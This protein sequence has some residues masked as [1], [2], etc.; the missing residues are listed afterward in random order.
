MLALALALVL[1][2]VWEWWCAWT[3]VPHRVGC[4]R[5]SAVCMY[6]LPGFAAGGGGGGDVTIRGPSKAVVASGYLRTEL[7]M[8][9]AVAGRCV[10]VGGEGGGGA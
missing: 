1:M 3:W 8:A 10:C 2:W 4:V 7:A 9:E 5:N 6:H